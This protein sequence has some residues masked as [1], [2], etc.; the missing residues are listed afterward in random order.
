M[1]VLST[2]PVAAV[3]ATDVSA[4]VAQCA[5]CHGADG[6]SGAMP[7]YG[8]IAGQN[9][10]YLAYILRQYRS[11]GP[12]GVNGGIMTAAV[13]H[14]GDAEIDALAAFYSTMP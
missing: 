3:A 13:R 1:L 11:G 10:E 4:Q 9:R 5:A 7:A 14:L 12:A 2:M 8:R 6:R